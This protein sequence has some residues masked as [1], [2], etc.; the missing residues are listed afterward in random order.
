V[1]LGRAVE[2][3]R[4]VV[5]LGDVGGGL[6]PDPLHDVALDVEPEDVPR[7]L[8]DLVD[9][10]GQLHAAGLAAAADLDL[11][12]DDHGVLQLLGNGN[13]VLDG[14]DGVAGGDRDAEGREEL[15][16][17]VLEEIHS[18]SWGMG[19]HTVVWATTR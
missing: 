11:G 8:A 9:V 16:A 18:F 7:V 2:G 19:G 6:D 15:L 13:G 14:V 4:G 5:L 10:L 1:L 3:E 17:L 12:L